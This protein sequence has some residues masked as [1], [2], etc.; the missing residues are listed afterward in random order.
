MKVK[1]KS[2]EAKDRKLKKIEISLPPKMMKSFMDNM[3]MASLMM[4]LPEI[5][6][7]GGIDLGKNPPKT[8]KVIKKRSKSKG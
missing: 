6:K 1:K 5:L 2:K 3:L 7:R 8:A 4:L